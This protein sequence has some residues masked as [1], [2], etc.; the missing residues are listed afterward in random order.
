M[1]ALLT[2]SAIRSLVAVQTCV[3]EWPLG[4]RLLELVTF[5]SQLRGVLVDHSPDAVIESIRLRIHFECEGDVG[6][7]GGGQVLDDVMED[8]LKLT[9]STH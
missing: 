3:A 1:P 7:V 6:S 2:D 5:R 8:V 9:N 4:P